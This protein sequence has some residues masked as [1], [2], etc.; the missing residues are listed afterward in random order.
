MTKNPLTE[1]F[2]LFKENYY[3]LAK[4]LSVFLFPMLILKVIYLS[5]FV[6]PKHISASNWLVLSILSIIFIPFIQASTTYV[7]LKAQNHERYKFSFALLTG[8]SYWHKLLLA[9]AIRLIVLIIAFVLVA[10]FVNPVSTDPTV[11]AALI[12]LFFLVLAY[13]L[14]RTSFIDFFIVIKQ[15]SALESFKNSYR[16]TGDI[17]FAVLSL[18]A[19]VSMIAF[20]FIMSLATAVP[21]LLVMLVSLI[22]Q[23]SLYAYIQSLLFTF[24]CLKTDS[25][26]ESKS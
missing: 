19:P 17:A 6:D 23:I 14:I 25:K 10:S 20:L 3:Q 18:I 9:N 26:S 8:L 4:V 16:C 22:V 11:T 15:D 12:F 24:F 21:G 2:L 13:I 1:A 7:L 5:N